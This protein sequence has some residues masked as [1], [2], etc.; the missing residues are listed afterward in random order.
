MRVQVYITPFKE[1]KRLKPRVGDASIQALAGLILSGGNLKESLRA[2]SR[3]AAEKIAHLGA[4]SGIVDLRKVM[5][6]K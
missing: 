2:A 4:Q 1:T 6:K 3:S 5:K